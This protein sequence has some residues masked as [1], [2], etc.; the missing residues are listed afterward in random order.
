MLLSL[1][2]R[3][4]QN[5]FAFTLIEQ[6]TFIHPAVNVPFHKKIL[7]PFSA[8]IEWSKKY[9]NCGKPKQ[10]PINLEEKQVLDLS[11]KITLIGYGDNVTL[12]AENTGHVCKCRF[13]CFTIVQ[14]YNA[15]NVYVLPL[16][17]TFSK[18]VHTKQ[19]TSSP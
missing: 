1:E 16:K 2:K 19:K 3:R 10:S 7:W 11:R 13:K 18:I 6:C 15:K 8:F 17:S 14:L 9:P 12:I 5:L 4:Q